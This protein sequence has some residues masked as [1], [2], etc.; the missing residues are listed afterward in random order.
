MQIRHGDISYLANYAVS[1]EIH[2]LYCSP[3]PVRL[4]A[5]QGSAPAE[6]RL[7]ACENPTNEWFIPHNVFFTRPMACPCQLRCRNHANYVFFRLSLKISVWHA[8]FTEQ[9]QTPIIQLL[10]RKDSGRRSDCL[11]PQDF[12]SPLY[13]ANKVPNMNECRLFWFRSLVPFI[14]YTVPSECSVLLHILLY[15]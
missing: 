15:W 10:S 1:T 14:T 4:R 6:G 12:A 5:P 2:L 13:L 8:K 11:S 7:L 3:T 9:L